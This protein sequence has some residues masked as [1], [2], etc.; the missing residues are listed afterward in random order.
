MMITMHKTSLIPWRRSDPLHVLSSTATMTTGL[1]WACCLV[2]PSPKCIKQKQEELASPNH[3]LPNTHLFLPS[4]T[5]TPQSGSLSLD[6]WWHLRNG[7]IVTTTVHIGKPN[8]FFVEREEDQT[9][10][11]HRTYTFFIIR[12]PEKYCTMT[13]GLRACQLVLPIP[14]ASNKRKQKLHHQNT[15]DLMLPSLLHRKVGVLLSMM[16]F[17]QWW[18]HDD[19]R[20]HRKSLISL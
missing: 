6:A 20:T 7:D 8:I 19:H 4:R 13:T 5:P 10:F 12:I 9:H 16:M 2:L 18:C 17:K 11:L 15:R 1:L 14:G 3:Q